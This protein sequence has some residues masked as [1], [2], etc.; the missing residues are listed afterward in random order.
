MAKNTYVST[1]ESKK[2]N[3]QTDREHFD[4]C[5][6]EES[7]GWVKMVKELRS[8]NWGLRKMVAR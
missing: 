8:T 4:G 3:K 5:L 2:Q 6:M 1:I 7:Q